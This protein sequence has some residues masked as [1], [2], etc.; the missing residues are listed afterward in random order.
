MHERE[1]PPLP[2]ATGLGITFTL[3]TGS[4][5]ISAEGVEHLIRSLPD[6]GSDHPHEFAVASMLE[7]GL[8]SDF[9]TDVTPLAH[10]RATLLLAL[11]DMIAHDQLT[12]ELFVLRGGLMKEAVD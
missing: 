8:R 12:D 10:D 4:Y 9:P 7:Y 2:V 5:L 1:P 3:A 11:E 6:V